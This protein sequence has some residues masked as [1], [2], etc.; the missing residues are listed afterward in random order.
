L[1]MRWI[2]NI[3]IHKELKDDFK[4]N[5]KHVAGAKFWLISNK[6]IKKIRV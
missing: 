6:L 5:Y 2:T 4:L 3:K 1:V